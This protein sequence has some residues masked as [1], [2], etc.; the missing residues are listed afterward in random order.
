MHGMGNI[1]I[2]RNL[3]TYFAVFELCGYVLLPAFR[4]NT[5]LISE[6]VEVEY[7]EKFYVRSV[8][9]LRYKLSQTN[10]C[11][12]FTLNCV[13]KMLPHVSNRGRVHPQG[14]TQSLITRTA[15]M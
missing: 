7:S 11:T 13:E 10:Q 3:I 9:C 1:K 4:T 14:V 8:H 2:K 6:S 12:L 15:T 5:L